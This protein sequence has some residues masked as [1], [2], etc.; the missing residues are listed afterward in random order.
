MI[1]KRFLD[2]YGEVA[3]VKRL[4]LWRGMYRLST[5][6]LQENDLSFS[7]I[8]Q[9]VFPSQLLAATGHLHNLSDQLRREFSL[10][11]PFEGG[12]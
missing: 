1:L 2:F 3:L 6:R 7:S 9:R 8:S 11:K 5:I 10:H 12:C 4:A